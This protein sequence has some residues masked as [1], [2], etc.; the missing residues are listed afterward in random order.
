MLNELRLR[1]RYAEHAS[2]RMESLFS[3]NFKQHRQASIYLSTVSHY[4]QVKGKAVPY[5]PEVTQRVPGS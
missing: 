2:L 4:Y 5:R 3:N 1:F